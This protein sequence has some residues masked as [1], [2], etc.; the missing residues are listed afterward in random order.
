MSLL[1][2]GAGGWAYFLI[3][4]EGC[5]R[6]YS[7]G[8]DFVEVNSTFYVFQNLRTLLAW[9]R[10]VPAG[11]EFSVRC[12]RKLVSQYCGDKLV[13]DERREMFL[14]SVERTC[15]ILEASVLTVLLHDSA[16]RTVSGSARRSDRCCR[17]PTPMPRPGFR[18]RTGH[19]AWM[20]TSR[21]AR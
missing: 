1:R 9:K 10:I 15:K 6:A 2:V 16:T 17:L 3:P 11:F 5:L 13:N 7:K 21:A 19:Q 4:D 12:N 20:W 14:E 18:S 8:F